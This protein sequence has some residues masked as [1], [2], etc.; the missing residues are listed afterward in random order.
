MKDYN[1]V[2]II[3]ND[4]FKE[5][6]LSVFI[7]IDYNIRGCGREVPNDKAP[8][9]IEFAKPPTQNWSKEKTLNCLTI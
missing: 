9:S 3:E 7:G 6:C 8:P 2:F 5:D 1:Y 4:G